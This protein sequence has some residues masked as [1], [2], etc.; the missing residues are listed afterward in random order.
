MLRQMRLLD[1][2]RD[3]ASSYEIKQDRMR[4]SKRRSEIISIRS[5]EVFWLCK[6]LWDRVSKRSSLGP[7]LHGPPWAMDLQ[8]STRCVWGGHAHIFFKKRVSHLLFEVSTVGAC[9]VC[10]WDCRRLVFSWLLQCLY[11]CRACCVVVLKW[12]SSVGARH[13]VLRVGANSCQI[14]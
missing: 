13:C 11:A 7:G 1:I 3:Q 10:A 4:S 6:I 12:S 14:W 2:I 9:V 8:L 5:C